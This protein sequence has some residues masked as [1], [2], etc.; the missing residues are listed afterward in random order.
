MTRELLQAIEN[1]DVQKVRQL[2]T[3]E[4]DLNFED[5]DGDFPLYVASWRGNKE[6]VELLLANGADVNYEAD[7]YFYTALMVASGAGH[8]DIVR[9]LLKHGANVNAEDD[10][11]LTSLMRV[12]ERGHLEVARVLLEHGANPSLRDDRRKTALELAEESGHYEVANLI[13]RSAK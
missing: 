11:Q 9:L 3:S 6:I 8:A 7:A 1:D 13:R 4:V 5:D 2:L 10:W 12:A